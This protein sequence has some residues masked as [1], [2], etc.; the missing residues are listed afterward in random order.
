[1]H[2]HSSKICESF[3]TPPL[4]SLF[5]GNVIVGLRGCRKQCRQIDQNYF[6]KEL[7]EIEVMALKVQDKVKVK[8]PLDI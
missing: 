7:G 8:V 3:H 6:E 1:M 5:V 4:V 2:S